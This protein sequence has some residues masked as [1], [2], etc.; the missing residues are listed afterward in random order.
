MAGHNT[1]GKGSRGWHSQGW[2][3]RKDKKAK[4]KQRRPG[5]H[6]PHLSNTKTKGQ[7]PRKEPVATEG[8]QAFEWR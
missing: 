3:A 4:M 8:A 2:Q 5:T 7:T 1:Q 6:T